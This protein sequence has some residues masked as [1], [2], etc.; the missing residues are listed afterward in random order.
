[1]EAWASVIGTVVAA[2]AFWTSFDPRVTADGRRQARLR[3]DL[4][5]L[6]AMPEG[7]AARRLRDEVARAA[8]KMLD[9]RARDKTVERAPWVLFAM[10]ALSVAAFTALPA[11]PTD[12]V[13]GSVLFSAGAVVAV[14]LLSVSTV[15]LVALAIMSVLRDVGTVRAWASR[16][17][18]A[19]RDARSV[20]DAVTE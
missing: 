18:A 12:T 19:K 14:G 7:A 15:G 17:S 2:L 8:D 20:E 10:F 11:V 1:M 13:W 6:A 4:E 16:R 3:R 5:L 9:E